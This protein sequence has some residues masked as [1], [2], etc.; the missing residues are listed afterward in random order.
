M[1]ANFP[2]EYKP[3]EIGMKLTSRFLESPHASKNM[4]N[5]PEVCVWYGALKYAELTGDDH[6]KN[7]LKARFDLLFGEEKHLLPI[8]GFFKYVK[9]HYVD[10]TVFGTLPLEFYIQTKEQRYLDLGLF[11][12]DYQWTLPDSASSEQIKYHEQGLSWQT[13]Y[14]ID[15]MYMITILQSKAFQ[16]T[17]NRKYIERAGTQMV[18]YLD[19]LQRVNGLF[20][21]APNAPFY[22]ARGNGWVAVGMTELLR[23]LPED[24]RNRA[25]VL[26][27]YRKM[28]RSLKEYQKADGT[29]GQL[30]DK[31]TIWTETSGSA[32]FTYAMITG[33]KHGWLDE[34]EY[35]ETSRKA[36]MALIPYINEEGDLTEVCIG[37]G[38]SSDEQF[39][40]DRPRK[41][42]DFHG[43]A[44]VLW[45]ANALLE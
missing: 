1:L 22:W 19:T 4:I 42:G 2:E 37:T 27:G 44:P 40:H 38:K 13:R 14:W 11:Y 7:Q 5:Y 18:S 6:V 30:I 17:G 24:D 43:Q 9:G 16:A 10:F 33:I 29:W 35:G 25:R 3:E 45:C 21:H 26:Q 15:D 41:I 32:M 39:Y 34:E 36:W 31:P 12:A 20:Y 23:Y 8:I 28:M